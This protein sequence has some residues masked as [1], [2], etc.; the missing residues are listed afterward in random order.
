MNIRMD[1]SMES[2][3]LLDI[4]GN[5]NRRRILQLLASRPCY[6]GEITERI[7]LGAKAVLGHLDMLE[8]T[9]MIRAD[10]NERRRKYYQITENL[11]LEVFLSPYSYTVETSTVYQHPS[12]NGTEEPFPGR[13]GDAKAVDA[14]K[15]LNRKL[16]E[17]ES[18][19]RGL[20]EQQRNI[21]G[22]MTDVMAQ[23]IDL[24]HNVAQNYLEADILMT[25][26]REPQNR[27][28]LSMNMGLPEYFIELH[29][30]SLVER[31]IMNE[32]HINN[33]QLL[34]LID[35]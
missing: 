32:R 18:R 15:N 7:G 1:R 4:L 13:A 2:T 20:A 8:Q 26:I 33:R 6:V 31:G 11:K 22:E 28:S 12:G 25:V 23:C 27:R 35:G 17:L 29:I 10:T 16:F 3:Q 34:T 14:L 24:L 9:G 21:E 5:K 19:R 30:Q